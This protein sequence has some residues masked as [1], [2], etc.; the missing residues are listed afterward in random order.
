MPRQLNIRSDSAFERSHRLARKLGR[1]VTEVVDSAL[2]EFEARHAPAEEDIFSPEA[3]A[4]RQRILTELQ[5]EVASWG[6][7]LPFTDHDLYD[8]YG[9][10]K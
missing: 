4:E 2:A 5:A 1:S 3:I 8:E 10:P 9:L 6:P 7:P